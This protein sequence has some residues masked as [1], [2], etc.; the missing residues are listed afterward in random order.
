MGEK[1][2]RIGGFEKLRFLGWPFW[3]FFSKKSSFIPMKISQSFLGSKCKKIRLLLQ[4]GFH[5]ILHLLLAVLDTMW[6]KC[7]WDIKQWVFFHNHW[8]VFFTFAYP[9]D[10]IDKT[11]SFWNDLGW[12]FLN[13]KLYSNINTWKMILGLLK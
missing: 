9:F 4:Q 8:Y 5:P 13:N 7:I 2:L 1:I 12:L 6:Q 3:N 10:K 11:N